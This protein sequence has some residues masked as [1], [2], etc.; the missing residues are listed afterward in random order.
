MPSFNLFYELNVLV[1]Q[2]SKVVSGTVRNTGLVAFGSAPAGRAQIQAL[3]RLKNFSSTPARG[4]VGLETL[5]VA[6]QPTDWETAYNE[7]RSTQIP[8][9]A[10]LRVKGRFSRQ[11]AYN[12]NKLLLER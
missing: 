7:G 9:N 10:V 8:V 1:T 11:L 2:S 5:G 3:V 4:T 12:G 6:W